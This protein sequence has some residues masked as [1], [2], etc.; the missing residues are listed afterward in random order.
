MSRIGRMP[1]T[2][3]AGVTVTIAEN[4]VVT[5]KG[6]LGTLT[7]SFNSH[8][9]D[10]L[11]VNTL[12]RNGNRNCLVSNLEGDS[13]G[14]LNAELSLGSTVSKE[15]VTEV[16]LNG[17]ANLCSLVTN[18]N[19]LKGL[20]KALGY[21]NNHVVEQR[22][23]QSMKA[24]VFLLVGRTGNGKLIAFKLY[25]HT[26]VKCFSESSKRSLNRNNIVFGNGNGDTCGN[27]DRHSSYSR[28]IKLPPA[29]ITKQKQGL[30]HR[31][32]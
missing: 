11:L 14:L 30:R 9:T 28:H 20:A 8:L 31:S 7:E 6:P 18:A 32:W 4:N 16:Q 24:S 17:L 13:C 23:S 12:Y 25:H 2:V 27:S 10:S 22:A 21:T 5:V 3:P 19:D 15:R 29:Q 1:I 26:A